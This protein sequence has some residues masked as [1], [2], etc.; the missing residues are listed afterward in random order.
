[1]AIFYL[2]FFNW[3]VIALQCH[4]V[5]LES[6]VCVHISYPSW[7]SRLGNPSACRSSQSTRL[8]SV[9]STAASPQLWYTWLC[10]HVNATFSTSPTLSFPSCVHKSILHI[11][12][13]FLPCKQVHQYHRSR[14]HTYALIYTL[15]FSLSDIS[16]RMPDSRFIPFTTNDPVLFLFMAEA[17][18][19][20]LKH[21]QEEA[22]YI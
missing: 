14:F 12:S 2:L 19:L 6:T 10:T 22:S 1:M 9:C 15:R 3:H 16:L 18:F 20:F 7:A 8:S 5:R 11:W 4:A 17:M 21:T 13:L